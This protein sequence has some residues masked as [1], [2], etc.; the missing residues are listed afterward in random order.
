[1]LR[2]RNRRGVGIEPSDSPGT[3]KCAGYRCLVY[4]CPHCKAYGVSKVFNKPDAIDAEV[5]GCEDS[6][7]TCSYRWLDGYTLADGEIGEPLLEEGM[8]P[9]LV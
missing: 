2:H 4:Y 7:S 9:W 6:M 1:M 3:Y 8:L 5:F